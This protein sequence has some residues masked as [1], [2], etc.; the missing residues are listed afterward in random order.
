MALEYGFRGTWKNHLG[1]QWV[2][3]LRIYR[4]ETIEHVAAIV[5]E[6]DEAGV[7]VR[8]VGSGHSWSDVA[9]T[10]G[11]LVRTDRLSRVPAPEPDFLRPEWAE[12]RLV[13]TEAGIRIRELNSHLHDQGLA[14]SNMGGY[15]HQTVAGVIS[16]S[17][18]G[19]GIGFGPLNDFV[20]SLDLVAGDGRVYR[21]EP[22]DGPTDRTAFEAHHGERRTLVQADDW[23]DAVC[24]GMGCM[25]IVC[26]AL[27]EVEASYFLREVRC[28][29]TWEQ[30]RADLEDGEVL[31]SNRHYELLFSPYRRK[32]A[33]PC[34][35]TTR[36]YTDDPGRKWF[37]KRMRNWFV[38]LASA[39]PPTP[40]LINLI[41]GI[42]PSLSPFLLENAIR[43][44]VKDE[45]DEVSYKVLN[46]GAANVLPGYSAEIGV[47]MDGRHI[48]AVDRIIEVAAE[49]RRV[50][51][52]YQSSPI[53]FRFVR[54]SPAHLSMMS[55]RDTMMIELI[56]LSRSEGGYELLA[57]YE[58]ALYDLGGRP[59][60]GQVNTLT[61][62][63][64]LVA[65]MYPRYEDWLEV[66]GHL[67]ANGA[68]DSPF[69]KRVGIS[70]DHYRP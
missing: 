11:F 68:F 29:A 62:S 35:V 58:D 42:K 36:N 64:G 13:R 27:L 70:E 31:R 66:H 63:H 60:W 25:G 55:G 30:V 19:S 28:F 3:P 53:A 12:R 44:L 59:H 38:E 32:H 54:A 14:L 51:D 56:Q 6:A 67:N 33:Y 45:Y 4:P 43:A 24:V 18:H 20:R 8:A 23:F 10:T 61:G 48:E 47:P 16:T 7:T 5:R 46:I 69:T 41:V 37:T 26:T 40:H 21:I 57:A 49:R 15:D 52:V 1:N 34:L 17:T 65:S 50:G 9:L 2:D 39:F 22:A